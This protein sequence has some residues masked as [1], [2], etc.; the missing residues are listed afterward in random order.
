MG[1]IT[2]A[3][4]EAARALRDALAEV[5]GFWHNCGD[6]SAL[7]LAL[8]RHRIEGEKRVAQASLRYG[9][10]P[11]QSFGPWQRAIVNHNDAGTA[12]ALPISAA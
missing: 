8:A 2:D 1:D 6:E 7:C 5:S 9:R 4:R 12:A 10:N 11:L 3:D